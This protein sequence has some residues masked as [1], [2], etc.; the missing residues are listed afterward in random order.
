MDPVLDRVC[1]QPLVAVLD[2]HGE[3]V[4]SAYELALEPVLGEGGYAAA[5]APGAHVSAVI[6][7]SVNPTAL[8]IARDGARS[9][10]SVMP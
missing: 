1:E 8:N 10:P 2:L 4:V 5:A 3:V 7:L 9:R 6:P